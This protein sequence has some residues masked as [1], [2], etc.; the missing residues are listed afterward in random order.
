MIIII[1]ILK[2]GTVILFMRQLFR[3]EDRKE[4]QELRCA[5]VTHGVFVFSVSK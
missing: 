3:I 4:S 2:A 1:I 5:I